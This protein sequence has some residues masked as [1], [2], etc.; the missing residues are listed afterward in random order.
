M[1]EAEGSGGEIGPLS[2]SASFYRRELSAGPV[3]DR[4][5]KFTLRPRNS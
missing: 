3:D 1:V 5:E 4:Y 2:Q